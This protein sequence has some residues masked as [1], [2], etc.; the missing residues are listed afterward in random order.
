MVDPAQE[1]PFH[2]EDDDRVQ[3]AYS[4]RCQPQVMG[5]VLDLLRYGASVIERAKDRGTRVLVR[6]P[7]RT[8][9]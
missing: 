1:V 2:L 7:L 8:T 9:A 5:A 3:D 4:L 6:I